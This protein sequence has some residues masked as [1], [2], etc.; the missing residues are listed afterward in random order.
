MDDFLPV[1]PT[2]YEDGIT[3]E[4]ALSKPDIGSGHY[5]PRRLHKKRAGGLH[6]GQESRTLTKAAYIGANQTPSML[7]HSVNKYVHEIFLKT[8]PSL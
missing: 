4:P 1:L 8:S 6:R 5:R 3:V 2:D 7:Q